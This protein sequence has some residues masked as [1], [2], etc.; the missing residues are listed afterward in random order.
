MRYGWLAVLVLLAAALGGAAGWHVRGAVGAYRVWVNT[1]VVTAADESEP[2]SSAEPEE[3]G[4]ALDTFSVIVRP[5]DT[6][7]SIARRMYPDRHTGE[8]VFE[9]RRLNPGIDPGRLQ[10]GQRIR[11]PKPRR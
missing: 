3:E 9:I 2:G 4:G 10:V 1:P 6:L 8:M 11:L 7:W 5:G